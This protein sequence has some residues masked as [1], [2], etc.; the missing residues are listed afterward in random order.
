MPTKSDPVVAC[1]KSASADGAKTLTKPQVQH[2]A[3]AGAS[4]VSAGSSYAIVVSSTSNVSSSSSS[5]TALAAAS[6]T[7]CGWKTFLVYLVSG[8]TDWLG[9]Y[10]C[11][12]YSTVWIS[13][14][15]QASCSAWLPGAGCFYNYKWVSQLHENYYIQ[16]NADYFQN[17]VFG[18]PCNHYS[19]MG[20]WNDGGQ[21]N[22]TNGI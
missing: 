1:I 2:C 4:V 5:R 6:S 10:F 15:P 20:I 17:C 3:P 14:G 9:G 21:D 8:I 16:I 12:N 22:G 11:W 19:W 18:G 13:I 7:Y